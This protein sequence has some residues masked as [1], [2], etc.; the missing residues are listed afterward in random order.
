MSLDYIPTF[1]KDVYKEF[2]VHAGHDDITETYG[3]YTNRHGKL[4]NIPCGI[5]GD[6][7]NFIGLQHFML[8]S[9]IDEWNV[10]F[11]QRPKAEV[12]AAHARILSAMLFYT[13]DVTYLEELHDLGYLP[14]EIKALEE[15]TLVPYGVPTFTT[16]NTHPQFEFLT[17]MIETV[18]SC[19]NWP[20]S[21]AATTSTAYQKQMKDAMLLSGMDMSLLPFMIHDFSNRGIFGKVAAA[22]SGFSHLCSGS[23]GTDTI[24]AVPFAE[25]FYGA[26]V[27]TELVGAS[28]NATEHSVTCGALAA[29]VKELSIKGESRGFTLANLA[30][31][32]GYDFID[33][34]AR[35]LVAAEFLYYHYLMI[36]VAPEGILAVV[37]DTNDFWTTV[38][39]V[40]P[41][42]KEFILARNGKLVIRPDSGDPVDI[43]CGLEIPTILLNEAPT[44]QIAADQHFETMVD[45][46]REETDHGE[47][48]ECELEG[49]FRYEGSVYLV[50]GQIEWNRHDKQ[51]YY[52]DEYW[53]DGY[54]E[55]QLTVVQKG[56]VECLW[57]T[58]GGTVTDKGFIMLNDHIG[59]IYGDAITLARQKEINRRLMDKLFAP[60]VVL[61]VGSYSFQF[62]TR[63]THGSAMK[64]TNIVLDGVDT[65][66]AKD[67]KTDAKKKSARGFLKVDRDAHGEL[68]CIQNVTRAE[69]DT[70]L[71][72]TVFLNG[73]ITRFTTLAKIR[74]LVLSQL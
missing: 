22:M 69:A 73:K 17:L 59:A 13:V 52:V 39:R 47:M 41:A 40:I 18:A 1:R 24:S 66:I 42:L 35:Y 7:V 61:G 63:D 31:R 62:V 55:V 37:A 56:L 30:S 51:Y 71:L 5:L 57:D 32:L 3:N 19:E 36:D 6:K 16:R 70:G 21:T 43:L 4:S 44:L 8:D 15:G 38:N 74:A 28:V 2:H 25:K 10:G 68:Y 64:A 54:E 23:V 26:N 9:L 14:L 45:V 33:T 49:H 34:E 11:F 20:M 46:V 27:D 29:Y 50:K 53:V 58:F 67:P 60:Q 12:C 65:P 72:K 48:G